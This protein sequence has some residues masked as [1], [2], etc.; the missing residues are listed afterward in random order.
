MMYKLRLVKIIPLL[1]LTIGLFAST[2]IVQAASLDADHQAAEKPEIENH[3]ATKENV[4]IPE[5][6]NSKKAH[7]IEFF[8]FMGLIAGSIIIPELFY[9]PRKNRHLPKYNKNIDSQVKVKKDIELDLSPLKI[10][11]QNA[12]NL[13]SIA[14]DLEDTNPQD[15]EAS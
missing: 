4:I 14:D 7:Q 13:S 9:N 3:Q 11:A 8:A 2:R 6:L 10:V 15:K 12:Q 1:T 5:I